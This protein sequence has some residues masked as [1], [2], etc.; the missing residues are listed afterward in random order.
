MNDIFIETGVGIEGKCKYYKAP[1]CHPL[2]IDPNNWIYCCY[3][4]SQRNYD[5]EPI[6]SCEGEISNCTLKKKK[7]A[8]AYRRGLAL[9]VK[10]A[11]A[12]IEKWEQAIMEFDYLTSKGGRE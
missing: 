5:F 1:S 7:T 4:P 3:H 10:N 9:R 6:V 8:I 2:Q 12:K 11:K